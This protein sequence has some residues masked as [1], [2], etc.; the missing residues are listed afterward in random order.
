[1]AVGD[2]VNGASNNNVNLAF[3]PAIGVSICITCFSSYAVYTRLGNA[4]DSGF[5][6]DCG[7][8]TIMA[9]LLNTKI[10]IN[11]T[12]YL[13]MSTSTLGSSY[14]GIQIQ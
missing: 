4:V 7:D 10:M 12:N 9:T 8:P 1:M 13:I 6:N 3:I 2:I 5:V 14:S 11:N